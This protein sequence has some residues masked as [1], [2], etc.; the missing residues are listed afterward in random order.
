LYIFN[1]RD[2]GHNLLHLRPRLMKTHSITQ[3]CGILKGKQFV[4]VGQE[5]KIG[6][7]QVGGTRYI[8]Y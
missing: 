6:S 5:G 2:L 7:T 3:I 8:P 1:E 4:F